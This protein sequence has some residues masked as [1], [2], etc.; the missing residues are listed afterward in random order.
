MNGVTLRP[1]AARLLSMNPRRGFSSGT[2]GGNGCATPFSEFDLAGASATD[3]FGIYQLAGGSFSQANA[4]ATKIAVGS[5]AGK[6][7]V[8]NPSLPVF[9]G[10]RPADTETMLSSCQSLPT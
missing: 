2:R 7:W 5:L 1:Q 9:H 10:Q 4:E 6:P 3:N 8:I